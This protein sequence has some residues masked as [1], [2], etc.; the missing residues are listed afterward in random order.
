M[1]NSRHV[2]R[3]LDDAEN[4]LTRLVTRN[5]QNGPY[6][7]LTA[8]GVVA[9]RTAEFPGISS[10]RHSGTTDSEP[11]SCSWRESE[12]RPIRNPSESAAKNH[13]R[14]ATLE[15]SEPPGSL[16]TQGNPRVPETF[17]GD[18]KSTGSSKGSQVQIP[19]GP[20]SG[21]L[22][23]AARGRAAPTGSASGGP[24]HSPRGSSPPRQ[25]ATST[26]ITFPAGSLNHAISGPDAPSGPMRA[27]PFSS[28]PK[29]GSV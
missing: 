20:H 19:S 4:L 12:A 29:S 5:P 9:M 6:Q 15:P 25:G 14:P 21:L 27:M 10:D 2:V 17:G 3:R 26:E 13:H 18:R 23:S 16:E 11:V 1:T 22:A 8:G 7:S 28:V 24:S